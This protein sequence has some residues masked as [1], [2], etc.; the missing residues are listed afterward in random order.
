MPIGLIDWDFARPCDPLVDLAQACWLNAKLHDDQVAALEG[1]PS[2]A[3]R[4]KQLRAM[5][6]AY[7]LTV[8]QRRGFVDRIIEFVVQDTA[9]QA[10]D[11]DK[12]PATPD[13]AAVWALE[14]RARAAAW[15][16]THRR[17]LQ[18]ALV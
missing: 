8:A 3:E 1:L 16:Y 5:V 18:N 11:L 14:W 10:A 2:L 12:T 13:P 7:G 4:S 17:E 6:D 9:W 15:I